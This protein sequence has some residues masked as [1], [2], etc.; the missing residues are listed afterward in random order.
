MSSA[1]WSRRSFLRTAGAVG[2]VASGARGM[3][4][5]RVLETSASVAN[6]SPEEIAKDEFY[7]REIQMDFKLDRTI[8]NLN[9]G[10]TCPTPRVALES[11]FRYTDMINMAPIFYQY[12]IA[13]RIQTIRL[14][15][16]EEF[17]C[18]PEEMALT[19]GASESLQ[20]VQ[21]G[22]DLKAG[23]EVIT[24]EQDYPRMLTTW[25]QRMRREGI[26]V[27][28]LQFPVPT[29]ADDLYQRFEKAITPKTKVF[30]FCHVTNL[31]AQLFPVQRLSR[32]ARSRG[33]VTIV[34]GAH[35]LGQFPFK[36]RDLECDAYGVSL[37]KW[38]LAP[39]GNGCLYV[40]KEMI[41][42]FWP[43]QAAP[44]Q[45]DDD[46]RKFEAIGTHPWGIRA[47]LGEALAYHQAIGGERKAARLRY[48]TLRWA[49]A[50]KVHPR[51]KILTDLSEPAQAWA[52]AAVNIEGIDVRDLSKFLMDKYRIIVVAL[53]G[54]APPN[55][56]FDYQCLRVSPNIYTTLEEID[57]FVRAMEDALKNGVPSTQASA[58][59]ATEGWMS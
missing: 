47:A 38:L 26:K 36:L 12:P 17:G 48:L 29:T 7:W 35:A 40:R 46:I 44:E 23:D 20:I 32:L 11:E 31:T 50:L 58:G 57:T 30:H 45:Q 43:L 14:R 41:P 52:I 56:V 24:T 34:D 51:I 25:D 10:F 15:M 33:I 21:N 55:Q 22:I 3:G 1:K 53:V 8:I 37:H 4:L 16:A 2:T 19:R 54:G 13:D 42:K 18:D 59:S 49:N 6:T 28:R 27:T 9:N 39:I 5:A